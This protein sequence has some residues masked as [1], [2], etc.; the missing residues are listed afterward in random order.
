MSSS[1]P[2]VKRTA[3]KSSVADNSTA[4]AAQKGRPLDSIEKKSGPA[5]FRKLDGK[6]PWKVEVSAPSVDYHQNK[7]GIQLGKDKELET[8]TKPGVKRTLFSKITSE[9]RNGVVKAGSRVVPYQDEISESTVVVSNETEDLCRN[10]KDCE[11]LSLI[12]KQLAQIETQQ[13]NLLDLLQV[14]F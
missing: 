2:S 8:H 11:D 6:K 13:S 3:N 1:A 10:P 5:I 7:D 4:P 14:I 9:T 12:R